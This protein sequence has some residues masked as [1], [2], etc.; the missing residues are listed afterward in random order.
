MTEAYTDNALADP[1]NHTSRDQY[2]FHCRGICKCVVALLEL[3]EGKERSAESKSK[4]F[5]TSNFQKRDLDALACG[6]H[7]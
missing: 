6:V 2:V 1:A 4:K 5:G 3:V 7:E